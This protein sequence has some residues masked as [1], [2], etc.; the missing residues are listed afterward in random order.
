MLNGQ[1]GSK[2]FSHEMIAIVHGVG[3]DVEH[4][5][6]GD[7]VLCLSPGNFDSSSIVRE[8]MCYPLLPEDNPEEIVGSILPMCSALYMLHHIGIVRQK[9][10]ITCGL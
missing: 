9:E 2:F 7:R 8:E 6:G 5:R 4:L 3:S 10:V 1:Q